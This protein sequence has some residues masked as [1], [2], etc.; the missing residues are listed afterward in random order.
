M[1]KETH[2]IFILFFSYEAGGGRGLFH[3][4]NNCTYLTNYM[5]LKSQG[6]SFLRSLGFPM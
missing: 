2:H 3:L 5:K 4:Y 6:N 1:E